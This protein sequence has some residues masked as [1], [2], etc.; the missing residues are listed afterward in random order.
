LVFAIE[1]K[2]LT[3][4]FGGKKG[5]SHHHSGDDRGEKQLYGDILHE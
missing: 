4:S 3:R 1:A 2:S 5:L